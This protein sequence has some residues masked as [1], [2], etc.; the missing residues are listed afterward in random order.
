MFNK[1]DVVKLT[2]FEKS[3]TV[4]VTGGSHVNEDDVPCFNGTIIASDWSDEDFY[5]ELSVGTHVDD[6]KVSS[7]VKE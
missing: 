7:F 3:Y 5:G 2:G 1:G 6:F 4:I